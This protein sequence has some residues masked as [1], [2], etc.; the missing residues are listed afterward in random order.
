VTNAEE[1]AE[2]SGGLPVAPVACLR[3]LPAARL[4]PFLADNPANMLM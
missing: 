1:L 4:Y 3:L 2:R